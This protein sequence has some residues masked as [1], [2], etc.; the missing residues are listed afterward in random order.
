[1]EISP[2]EIQN[3]LIETLRDFARHK[4]NASKKF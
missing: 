3:I 4:V 1:M 2:K